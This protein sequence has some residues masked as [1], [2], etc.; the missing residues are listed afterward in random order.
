MKKY[1]SRLASVRCGGAGGAEGALELTRGSAGGAVGWE[2]LAGMEARPRR[3]R[4]ITTS[5]CLACTDASTGRKHICV[6]PSHVMARSAQG[7]LTTLKE[8]T[9]LPLIYPDVFD[10]IGA[11]GPKGV[12]LYGPPGWNLP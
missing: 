10:K 9:L 11:G 6:P 12:L 2:A 8:M 4:G 3:W 1:R 7:V 5:A